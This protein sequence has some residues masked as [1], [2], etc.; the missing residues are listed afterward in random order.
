[1]FQRMLNRSDSIDNV[2]PFSAVILRL[3]AFVGALAMAAPGPSRL[4]AQPSSASATDFIRGA[5]AP[6]DY[7]LSR[8]SAHRV[9]LLGEP[10]WVRHDV[11]LLATLVPRL[12]EAKVNTFAA[13]WLPARE[14]RRI[15]ALMRSSI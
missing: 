13:E 14:Q 11:E 12:L 9:V 2:A 8:F 5:A 6:A 1:M 7:V 10:H 4:A 15:D 3:A